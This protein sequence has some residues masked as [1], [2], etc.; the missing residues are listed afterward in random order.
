MLEEDLKSINSNF[1]LSEIEEI[2]N[3]IKN[4]PI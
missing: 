3:M 1:N 2:F 4:D